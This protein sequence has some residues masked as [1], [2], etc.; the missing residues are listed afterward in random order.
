MSSRRSSG[1]SLSL[2]YGGRSGSIAATSRSFAASV[3][4]R[5]IRSM[6]RLRAVVVS[7]ASG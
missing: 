2:A 6:A 5:R 4:A 1:I 7:H 3:D